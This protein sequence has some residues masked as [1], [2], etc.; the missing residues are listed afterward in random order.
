MTSF[1]TTLPPPSAAPVFTPILT[2]NGFTCSLIS[3]PPD[4][5]ADLR[6]VASNDEQLLFVV[7]GEAAVSLGH[8]VTTMLGQ[9]AALLIPSG[10]EAGIAARS[11]CRTKVLRVQIPPRSVRAPEIVTLS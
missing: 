4:G 8:D 9:H 6:L 10:R 2:K 11:G 1:I 7:D 3:L 5:E